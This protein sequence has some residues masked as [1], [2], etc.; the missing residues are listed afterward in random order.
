MRPRLSDLDGLFSSAGGPG[1][2]AR[3]Y[4]VSRVAGYDLHGVRDYQPGESLR[5]VH[6]KT[7]A[8]RR[9]LMVKEFEDTPS[10]EAV[11]L[12]DTSAA[13]LA[14][15]AP[16]SS[17]ELAVRAAG[18]IARHLLGLRHPHR[19]GD[20]RRRARAALDRLDRGLEQRARAALDGAGHRLAPPR[21]VAGRGARS[22]RRAHLG[23][24]R[25][26]RPAAGPPP[27]HRCAARGASCPWP[28][29]TAARGAATPPAVPP[30]CSDLARAAVPV[31]RLTRGMDLRAA[32]SA[33][34]VREEA[35]ATHA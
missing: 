19:A 1:G 8:R 6:W 5:Q 34:P 7:T 17:F 29:S 12:L 10:D 23:R 26:S 13:G 27:D 15:Q 3:R 24:D 25:R 16:D 18:S 33:A 9:R 4:L 35:R 22:R 11:V 21:G 30:R 14:G 2:S 20:A 28:G 31:A 32:L